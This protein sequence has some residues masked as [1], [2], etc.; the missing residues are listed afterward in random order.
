MILQSIED[1]K[2]YEIK[3]SEVW[4]KDFV[5]WSEEN[6]NIAK[7][8]IYSFVS[9]FFRQS[10]IRGTSKTNITYTVANQYP[11]QS[12]EAITLQQQKF[13]VPHN[14]NAGGRLAAGTAEPRNL[15]NVVKPGSL[16]LFLSLFV[17]CT[18][19]QIFC[20]Q[21]VSLP[22]MFSNP[23]YKRLLFSR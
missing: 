22:M 7:K 17:S 21:K 18:V 5:S 20:V 23:T 19:A 11:P 16:S 15:T 2:N 8:T 4:S 12:L 10:L 14:R 1:S 3:S 9:N 6:K 13:W